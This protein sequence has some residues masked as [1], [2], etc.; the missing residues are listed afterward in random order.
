MAKPLRASRLCEAG[1][2]CQ[3]R[4]RIVR[5]AASRAGSAAEL[6][7]L[8]FAAGARADRVAVG[9]DLAVR[10]RVDVEAAIVIERRAAPLEPRADPA[11]V[12]QDEVDAVLAEQ[13]G[14]DD[15]AGGDAARPAALAPAGSGWRRPAR[16]GGAPR[17][18]ADDDLLVAHGDRRGLAAARGAP[19]RSPSAEDEQQQGGGARQDHRPMLHRRPA[20]MRA[21]EH[22]INLLRPAGRAIR[23]RDGL[24]VQRAARQARRA[25]SGRRASPAIPTRWRPG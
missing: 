12:A 17:R 8:A 5:S 18:D 4:R 21:L 24:S 11:V 14:A 15:P 22:A 23:R 25:C 9:A 20:F 3:A 16:A 1:R 7:D 19:A 2:A 13:G 10:G 6:L